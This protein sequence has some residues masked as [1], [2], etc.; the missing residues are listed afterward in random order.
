MQVSHDQFD[1]D[2]AAAH[3][4]VYFIVGMMVTGTIFL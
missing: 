4:L 1:K 3:R 2:V